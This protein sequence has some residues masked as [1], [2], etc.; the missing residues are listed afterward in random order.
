M[1]EEN[2]AV[3]LEH[4]YVAYGEELVL[5][6]VSLQVRRGEFVGILGPNGAGKSTLLKVILG[7]AKPL[8]GTVRIFGK[9]QGENGSISIGY[10]PQI[11]KIDASFPVRVWDVVM[12]GRYGLIGLM[13]RPGRE[14]RE[15]VWR[16]LERVEMKDLAHRQIGQLSGGQRQ[17][18]LVA[19]ALAL[20]PKLLLLDE[21]T[22]SMDVAVAEGFYEFLNVLHHSLDLTIML[23][24]HDVTVISQYTDQVACL[25]RRLM[26]HGKP[27]EVMDQVALECMYGQ[28]AIFFAHGDVPHMVVRKPHNG[29]A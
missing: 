23:V 25:N 17:R 21:P 20:E 8:R 11:A 4:V 6:D 5:E 27:D 9:A 24:S 13:R 1:D 18:V 2:I 16:A 19:R 14:D 29:G 26:V 22:S 3:E 10:V 15:A 12:M 28:G 7:L